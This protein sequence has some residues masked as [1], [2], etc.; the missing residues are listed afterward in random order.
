MIYSQNILN[1]KLDFCDFSKFILSNQNE[2]NT[3]LSRQVE[4]LDKYIQKL[5][6]IGTI[7][8]VQENEIII[9]AVIGYTD[10]TPDHASHISLIVVDKNHRGKGI[11]GNLLREYEEVCRKKKLHEMWL[12]TDEKNLSAK[13]A[14]ENFGFVATGMDSKGLIIFRKKVI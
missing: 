9:G 2:F 11:V 10:N 6:S 4:D 12:T 7:A 1:S 13:K 5:Y 14:Y 8:Y 3:P